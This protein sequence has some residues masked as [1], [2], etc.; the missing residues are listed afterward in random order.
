[1]TQ[2]AIMRKVTVIL[3]SC[4]F[5]LGVL[6]GSCHETSITSYD[7]AHEVNFV[8][9]EEDRDVTIKVEE[10]PAIKAEPDEVSYLSVYPLLDT[11]HQYP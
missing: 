5:S 1:M 10:I 4:K 2:Y 11:C 3:Q 7:D 6:P 9:V 8:K